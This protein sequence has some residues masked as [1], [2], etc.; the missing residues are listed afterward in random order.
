MEK[1]LLRIDDAA[2]FFGVSSHSIRAWVKK[3]AIAPQRIPGSRILWF[4]A[5]DLLA[6]VNIPKRGRPQL[7]VI[8]TK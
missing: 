7:R 5:E 3:G 4:R 6:A 1:K 2:A 8:K